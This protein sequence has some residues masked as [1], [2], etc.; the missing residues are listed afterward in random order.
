MTSHSHCAKDSASCDTKFCLLREHQVLADVLLKN[1]V[2]AAVFSHFWGSFQ[3]LSGRGSEPN[4]DQ[5]VIGIISPEQFYTFLINKYM[6]NFA[7]QSPVLITADEKISRL[8]V[9]HHFSPLP[10]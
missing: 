4:C 9:D 5:N 2:A 7:M 8:L 6:S 3:K 1:F 10:N